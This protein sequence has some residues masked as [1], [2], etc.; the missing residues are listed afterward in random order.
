MPL[1]LDRAH[2]SLQPLV[3]KLSGAHFRLRLSKNVEVG[4]VENVEVGGWE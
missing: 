1:Y 4:G 3:R 2:L